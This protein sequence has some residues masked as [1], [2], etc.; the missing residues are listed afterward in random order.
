MNET[1]WTPTFIRVQKNIE[2]FHHKIKRNQS[3]WSN[4]YATI[5][6]YI[7]LTPFKMI[8]FSNKPKLYV[9]LQYMDT[10]FDVLG[11]IL[12]KWKIL[13]PS[14]ELIH[15]GKC[16]IHFTG[17]N[18]MKTVAYYRLSYHHLKIITFQIL[19]LNKSFLFWERENGDKIRYHI[20][21]KTK[22]PIIEIMPLFGRSFIWSP[23]C[24]ITKCFGLRF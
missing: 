20:L 5:S 16:V 9:L 22:F 6:T 1:N 8:Y 13:F 15:G 21:F 12:F 24:V 7:P 10:V 4:L 11:H 23:S 17:K 3:Y 2:N 18:V 19:K 14:L